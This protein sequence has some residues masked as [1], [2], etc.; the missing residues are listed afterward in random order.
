MPT[1]SVQ[2]LL[3]PAAFLHFENQK[4]VWRYIF[5]KRHC[6]MQI[7]KKR[8][9][10]RGTG[11]HWAYL[12]K[13]GWMLTFSWRVTFCSSV[14][15]NCLNSWTSS[16]TLIYLC[17]KLFRRRS[18]W[19]SGHTNCNM[20][21]RMPQYASCLLPTVNVDFSQSWLQSSSKLSST[22]CCLNPTKPLT[23]K[24]EEQKH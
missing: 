12:V 9:H 19:M 4:C 8:H 15:N 20:W 7:R 2:I 23:I 24:A 5:L 16:G 17:I 22:S 14:D 11:L 18:A 21:H 13:R 3:S 1:F 6:V 10:F